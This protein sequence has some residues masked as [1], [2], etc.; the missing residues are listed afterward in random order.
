MVPNPPDAAFDTLLI[1]ARKLLICWGSS[2]PADAVPSTQFCE[3]SR[4][5]MERRIEPRELAH[6][7]RQQRRCRKTGDAVTAEP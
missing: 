7:Y 2:A 6:T 5:A 1:T 4:S 3:Y